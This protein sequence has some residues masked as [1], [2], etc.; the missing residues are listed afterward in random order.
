MGS[1]K[2]RRYFKQLDAKNLRKRRR[3][4][5]AFLA[6]WRA[7]WRDCMQEKQKRYDYLC[8]LRSFIDEPQKNLPPIPSPMS[9]STQLSGFCESANC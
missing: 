1:T 3:E 2:T 7:E 5:L 8:A 6:R 4:Q 9:S